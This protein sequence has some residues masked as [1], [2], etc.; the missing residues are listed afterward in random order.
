MTKII[1]VS[2][3]R[4]GVGK[5]TVTMMLAYGLSVGRRQKVL[6][7]DLDAQASTSIV[8]MGHQRW[9]AAREAHRTT[10]ALLT[11]IVNNEAIGC[12]AYISQGIGDVSL[13]DG[14]APALDIIPS[15]HDLDDKEALLMIAQQARFHK[16]SDAFD[17]MQDRMGKII[18]YRGGGL[19]PGHHRLRSGAFAAGV[20]RPARRRLTC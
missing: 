5:T 10:S 16:I 9:R 17:N 6:V 19:R 14:S 15:A 7:V 18:R 2:N 4:G 11:Q 12:K 13:A 8:M 1:A 3:R 20:G